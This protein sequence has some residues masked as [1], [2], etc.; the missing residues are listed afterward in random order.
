MGPSVSYKLRDAAGQ[1]REYNNYMLPV[2]LGDGTPVFLLGMRETPSDPFRYLR[3]PAD[4]TGSLSGFLRLR[5]ALYDA[6]LRERAAKRYASRAVDASRTDLTG[7][8]ASSALRAL[9]LFAGDGPLAPVVTDPSKPGQWAGL[10]GI[11]DFIEAN[12]PEA[13]RERAGQ[14]LVRILNGALYELD[15]VARQAQGVAPLPEDKVASFMTQALLALSDAPAY[16]A[17]MVVLLQD[18]THVQASVFQVAR[19]PGK[20]L[21]YLG[22]FFLIVGIFAML[23]VR[24]RRMWIWLTPHAERSGHSDLLMAFSMNRRTRD[25]EQEFE[26]WRA[27]LEGQHPNKDR[28]T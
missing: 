2:D 11:A 4:E 19:A 1:A 25:G 24:E 13:E 27:H 14:M 15:V 3:P 16:P 28:N 21:V 5:A 7:Q 18:F 8:L 10:Q 26:R 17:P 6:D 20:Y 12:V 9:N 23:Y 22:C